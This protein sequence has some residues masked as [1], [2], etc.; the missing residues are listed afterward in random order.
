MLIW[1]FRVNIP[2][3][4]ARLNK[5]QSKLVGKLAKYIRLILVVVNVNRANS[6]LY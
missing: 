3:K 5:I 1:K 2:V 4:E 6:L